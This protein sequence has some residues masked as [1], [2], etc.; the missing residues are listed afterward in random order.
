[1]YVLCSTVHTQLQSLYIVSVTCVCTL[2]C[3]YILY[4]FI[5]ACSLH[6]LWQPHHS[7]MDPTEKVPAVS[8]RILLKGPHQVLNPPPPACRRAFIFISSSDLGKMIKGE[9]LPPTLISCLHY[10][11]HEPAHSF[12]FKCFVFF[13]CIISP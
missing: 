5:F 8:R 9:F 1:M 6:E 13:K 2:V 12:T 10:L 7:G 4:V 3:A 11:Q